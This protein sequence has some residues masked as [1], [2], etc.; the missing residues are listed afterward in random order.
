MTCYNG[1]N[2]FLIQWKGVFMKKFG[3]VILMC[4][5]TFGIKSMD[6]DPEIPALGTKM[7]DDT[8]KKPKT[9]FDFGIIKQET[10]RS[11]SKIAALTE[12][13]SNVLAKYDRFANHMVDAYTL[14]KISETDCQKI[15]KALNFAAQKHGC[16]GRDE[17]RQTR[18]DAEKT[19]YIIHPIGVAN[20]VLEV[21]R[22]YDADVIIAALL[23]DT[24]E[25]THTAFQEISDQFGERVKGF[26]REVTDDKLQSKE[27]RKE[28]QIEH[29]CHKSVEAA[30]VKYADKLYN[31]TDLFKNPPTNWTKDH[32]IEYFKW[33]QQVVNKLPL[34]NKELRYAVDTIIK[35]YFE[36]EKT[37]S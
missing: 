35:T 27:R 37:N 7:R 9:Q 2:H 36:K 21:G 12:H 33:A 17:K 6:I 24:V 25:D 4:T 28:L 15:F 1:S 5:L 22:V 30:I 3:L 10:E 11:R 13:N 29:A 16:E 31:L 20:N 18:K 8:F 23:H 34:A 32:I 14:E 19:P 26:V